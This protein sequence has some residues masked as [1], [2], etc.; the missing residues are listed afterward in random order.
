[1]IVVNDSSI[2]QPNFLSL[3]N[4]TKTHVL[5]ELKS[6][7]EKTK[8]LNGEDF[9]T[10]VY[11]NCLKAAQNTEFEG[12]VEQKGAHAFPDIIAKKYFGIEV[13]MTISD[14]WRSTGN[15]ILE[16]T[17][18]DDVNRIYMF[19]GKLGGNIDVKFRA[20]QECLY[21]IGV[22]HS[23]RY[24]IDMN[25]ANGKSI[26]SKMNVDYEVLRK[27]INPIKRIKEYYKSLLQEGEELW[28]IDSQIEEKTVNPII[29]PFRRL[30]K[31]DQN[32]F[33]AECFVLFP[34]IL[35]PVSNT[36]YEKAA[37][38]LITEYNAVHASLR[39]SFSAGGKVDLQ[40]NGITLRQIPQVYERFKSLAKLIQKAISDISEEKLLHYWNVKSLKGT[41]IEIWKKMINSN[42]A[43][44]HKKVKPF[45]IYTWG[46]R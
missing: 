29:K 42:A 8:K 34:E 12:H 5:N 24:K 27:E 13:K 33:V 9:E 7:G 2:L 18:V 1:M 39:D 20:Y 31:D 25:L 45:D 30:S 36:K 38:Y 15:S 26:F 32:K 35:G 4:K 14:K 40:I 41:R 44:T 43:F 19:F 37:T 23:P 22:T 46:L 17:R 21:D 10:I 16:T 28:W 6:L 3:L 11:N